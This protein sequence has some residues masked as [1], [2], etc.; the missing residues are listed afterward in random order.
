[1][2][3]GEL[4]KRSGLSRD[5]IRFYERAGLIRSAPEPAASNGYRAYSE[6]TLVTL[7][8]IAD[9]QAAGM[10]LADLTVFLGELMVIEDGFDGDAF[11]A[12]KLAEAEDRLRRTR[13]FIQTLKATRKALRDAPKGAV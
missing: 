9:A 12:A 8:I 10:T 7:E 11:L 6:D 5:T 3:I 1:M 2:R 4:A 13:R